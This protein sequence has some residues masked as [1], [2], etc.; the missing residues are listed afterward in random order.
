M[1]ESYSQELRRSG[2]LQCLIEMGIELAQ[3]E[4]PQYQRQQFANLIE[5]IN[6][7]SQNL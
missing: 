1:K 2:Y 5:K 7:K 4:V 6:K 3:L